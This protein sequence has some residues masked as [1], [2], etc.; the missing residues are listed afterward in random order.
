[1][2]SFFQLREETSG[3]TLKVSEAKLPGA[4]TLGVHAGHTQPN[5][6]NVARLGTK[7]KIN[8]DGSAHLKLKLVGH[9]TT[10]SANDYANKAAGKLKDKGYTVHKVSVRK[11]ESAWGEPQHTASIHLSHSG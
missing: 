11:S 7:K 6:P 4:E 10:D 5:H 2:K 9:K 1:M 8:K 3:K